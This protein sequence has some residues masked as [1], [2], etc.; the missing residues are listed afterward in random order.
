MNKTSALL[1]YKLQRGNV[2]SYEELL[3]TLDE[4]DSEQYSV[5]T[6]SQLKATVQNNTELSSVSATYWVQ[7]DLYWKLYLVH[8]DS[9]HGGLYPTVNTTGELLLLKNRVT[10]SGN[11]SW[12]DTTAVKMNWE[13]ATR[14][15]V[16]L[17]DNYRLPTRSELVEALDNKAHG[18][19]SGV[20]WSST[21][22]STVAGYVWGVDFSNGCV[23]P[24]NNTGT[25]YVRCVK[26]C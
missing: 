13:D 25:Y 24:Y 18:F 12:E 4:H 9:V 3:N 1:N 21:V 11:L 15:A 20:Y 8:Y 6:V 5:P 16:A 2:Y 23:N 10:T 22:H 17:E 7:H 14:Y 26:K 19:T